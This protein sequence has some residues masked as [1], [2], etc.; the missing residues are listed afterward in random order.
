MMKTYT[1][2]EILTSVLVYWAKPLADKVLSVRLG[3][4]Q[5]V[6]AANEW[7][8]KYFPV[9]SNYSIVNDLSFLAAPAMEMVVEPVVRNGIA[10]LGVKDED[11]PGYASKLLSSMID[12]ADKKGSV[13][14]F[15]TIELEKSDLVE[16][17]HLLERNLPVT[18][19]ERYEVMQ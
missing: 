2:S 15:N 14:L 6:Q 13:S 16:L 4:F 7:V 9:A 17:Q 10:K 1:N 8:K 18:V 11:I 12:E 5:P 19:T 3:Q